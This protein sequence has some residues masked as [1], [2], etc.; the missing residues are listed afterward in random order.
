MKFG[1]RLETFNF[2]FIYLYKVHFILRI[3]D[4]LY[5]VENKTILLITLKSISKMKLI[6]KKNESY[7]FRTFLLSF[8][9]MTFNRFL[10]RIQSLQSLRFTYFLS[11]RHYPLRLVSENS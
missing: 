8:I 6:K 11:I 3:E 5:I 10:R 4:F 9:S 2:L 1:Y 7:R